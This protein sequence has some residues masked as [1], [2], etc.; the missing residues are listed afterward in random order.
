MSN[1]SLNLSSLLRAS[2]ETWRNK[3]A[4]IQDDI[5]ITYRDF[6]QR[7]DK[8]AGFLID[9]GV[10][11]GDR[12]AFLF[13]NQWELLVTYHAITRIGAVTVSINYRLTPLEMLYQLDE[14]QSCALL[15]DASYSEV[16][17]KVK[18]SGSKVNLYVVANGESSF[19]NASF[20]EIMARRH[21]VVEPDRPVS[22]A[23]DAG[24]WFTSGTTGKPKGAIARHSSAIWAAVSSG[25]LGINHNTRILSVAPMFHRGA[26]EIFHLGTTLVGGTHYL[27]PRFDP[28]D[29]LE[30]IQRYEINYAFIVPTMSRMLVDFPGASKFDLT[31]LQTWLSASAPLSK[32]LSDEVRRK[33][34]LSDNVLI[35]A[36]GITE[37]LVNTFG[38]GTD[39]IAHPTTV[40]RP[41]PG[42]RL[43]VIRTDGSFAED[44][45]TGE[46]VSSGPTT[47]RTYIN[48]ESA[49]EAATFVADGAMWYRTGDMGYRDSEGFFYIVD[50][51]KDMIITGG[52]NV[53]C[54]EVESA[55]AT[56]P[57]VLDIAVIGRQDEKWGEA[58]IAVVVQRPGSQLKEEDILGCCSNLA[59]YKWPREVR[60]I[61]QMP[62]N[63]F[64]K[65][66][67]HELRKMFHA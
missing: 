54:V 40:G 25:F 33:F 12:V 8:L 41:V 20:S 22:A 24:I 66:Q 46:I 31:S 39:L 36:Y 57:Q 34:R 7:V 49:F 52:E 59:K 37:S 26:A 67:K 19:A 53:Y 42:M 58:V 13:L 29:V 50:R 32:D 48:N 35:N 21:S 9:S 44:G 23:D 5:T 4:I 16:V 30:R 15:Y 38:L 63:T 17:S 60:F 18:E 51:S 3:P 61:D 43:R 65:L 62:R 45:E 6:D 10:K 28:R 47:F 27:T 2:A 55:I 64:G 14:S 11:F 56:H 1:D